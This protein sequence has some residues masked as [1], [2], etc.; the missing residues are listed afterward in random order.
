MRPLMYVLMFLPSEISVWLSMT[1]DLEFT[2]ALN[3]PASS[4]FIELKEKVDP[5]AVLCTSP[6]SVI[7]QFIVQTTEVSDQLKSANDRLITNMAGV[8]K[9]IGSVTAFTLSQSKTPIRPSH[10]TGAHMILV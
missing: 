3:D 1:V 4:E 6:G 7:I 10:R 5:V 9:V 8:A 2:Q